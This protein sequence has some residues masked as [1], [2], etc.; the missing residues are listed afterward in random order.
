VPCG[1]TASK[2]GSPQLPVGMQLIG[3]HFEEASLL[4]LARA[5]EKDGGFE[6]S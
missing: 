5:F 3:R 4:Q 6:L 2:Y 1:K